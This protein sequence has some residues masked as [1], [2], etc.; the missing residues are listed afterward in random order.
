[1]YRHLS[2]FLITGLLTA[3]ASTSGIQQRFAVCSYD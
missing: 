3:C 2:L 1:M